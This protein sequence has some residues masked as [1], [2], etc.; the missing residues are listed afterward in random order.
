MRFLLSL[1]FCWQQSLRRHRNSLPPSWRAGSSRPGR[2]RITR[3]TYGVPHIYGKTD[4][5]AVFGLLYAQCEDDFDRVETN[6]LDAIGRLAEVEGETPALPRPA[7]PP[8]SG[9]HAGPQHLQEKPGRYEAAARCLCGRH[10]L[11]PGHPPHRAAPAA[12]PLPALDAAHVQR[13]QHW[14]QHQR[15]VAGAAEGLLQPEKVQL[16]D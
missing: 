9:Q 6:Y 10:Q 14:R 16:V 7:R 5:D 4:A 12:A 15:G 11:L 3:D 8:V 1:I 13:G 2:S